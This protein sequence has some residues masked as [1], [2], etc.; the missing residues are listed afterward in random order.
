M[1]KQRGGTISIGVALAL[2]ALATAEAAVIRHLYA[3]RV[4]QISTSFKP[5]EVVPPGADSCGSPG[6]ICYQ[7]I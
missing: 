4:I 5:V 3:H 1:N 2:L 7:K 6:A